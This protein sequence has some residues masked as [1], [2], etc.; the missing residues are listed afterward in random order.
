M[1]KKFRPRNSGSGKKA[2]VFFQ[3][4]LNYVQE[5]ILLQNNGA[6]LVNYRL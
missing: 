4:A 6:I 5:Q 3:Y 2:P 1:R